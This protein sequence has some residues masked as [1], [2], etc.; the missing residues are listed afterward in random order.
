MYV[1]KG[2]EQKTSLVERTKL[3]RCTSVCGG[4]ELRSYRVGKLG[5]LS[6]LLAPV[7]STKGK[8]VCKVGCLGYTT[9]RGRFPQPSTTKIWVIKLDGGVSTGIIVRQMIQKL[10]PNILPSLNSCS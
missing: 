10:L 5:I 1:P 8:G 6:L 7:V 3:R 2:E 4:R 9:G